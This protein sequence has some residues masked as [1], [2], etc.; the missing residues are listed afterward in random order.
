MWAWSLM[1]DKEEVG[2]LTQFIDEASRRSIIPLP[3]RSKVA[4]LNTLGGI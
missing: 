4:T 3:W 1:G 2:K